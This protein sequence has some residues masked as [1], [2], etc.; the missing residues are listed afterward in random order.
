MANRMR[1]EAKER[2]WREQV[3]LW[4]RSGLTIRQ[5]CLQHHVNEPNFYAWRR[6]LA[7]RD[8]VAVAP[9]PSASRAKAASITW[10]PVTIT[11]STPPMVEV[12]LP[13]GTVLRV[14]AGVESMTLERIL[15]ALHQ[16]SSIQEVRP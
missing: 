12:Q 3:S 14:P 7:R 16:V 1:S 9:A 5:Y 2:L 11:S 15:T 10:M 8:E 6:E 4:Q 13:T